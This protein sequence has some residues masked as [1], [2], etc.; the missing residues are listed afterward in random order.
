MNTTDLK[1]KLTQSSTY[2]FP[3]EYFVSVHTANSSR[4]LHTNSELKEVTEAITKNP[5]RC[6]EL[7]NPTHKATNNCHLSFYGTERKFF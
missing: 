5:N 1:C 4:L 7:T 3:F 6:N 2:R